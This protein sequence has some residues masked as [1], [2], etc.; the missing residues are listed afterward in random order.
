[1]QGFFVENFYKKGVV[2]FFGDIIFTIRFEGVLKG[3]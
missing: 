1:M 2:N 3:I